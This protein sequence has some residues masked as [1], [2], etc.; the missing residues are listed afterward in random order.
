[1]H[2][3][4]CGTALPD[5]S[6]FCS[7]CGLDLFAT[8]PM[9]RLATGQASEADLAAEALSEEYDQFQEL[10]RGGMAL[11]YRARE[12][13]LERDVA[14]KVLPA[15]FTFDQEFVERFQREARTAARLEHPNI[16]PIYR[17]GRAGQ[18]IYFVMKYLRG[19][20]LSD[21]LK[22]HGRLRPAEIRR[23]LL[24]AG[25][26]LGY[27]AEHG[28]V[29]R[30]VKPD[31]IMLDEFGRT[32]LTDFGIAKAATRQRLTGT[33]LSIVTPRYMS[34]E[35]ARAQDTDF[36]SDIYSLGIVAFQCLTG[37]APFDGD[38]AFQ[39]GYKHVSEPL[40]RPRL[41][42]E[43]ERSLYGV[44]EKMVAKEPDSRFQSAAELEKALAGQEVAPSV[45]RMK[46]RMGPPV[47]LIPGDGPPTPPPQPA[48]LEPT[49]ASPVV[50]PLPPRAEARTVPRQD[51][52][53]RQ[54]ARRVANRSALMKQG[55]GSNF[56]IILILLLL[57]GGGGYWF[58]TRSRPEAG[59]ALGGPDSAAVAKAAAAESLRA[60]ADTGRSPSTIR[61]D[62]T[63][64]ATPATPAPPRDTARDTTPAV[65]AGSSDSGAIRIRNLPEGS[66]V[67]IDEQRA[68]NAITTLPAGTH[69]V[70]ISAPR[71]RFYA[72]TVSVHRN[73]TLLLAPVLTRLGQAAPVAPPAGSAT[74]PSTGDP[75]EPGPDW[76][77]T[78][79]FDVRPRPLSTPFVALPAGVQRVQR[80]A[81]FWIYVGLSGASEEVRL[82]RSSGNRAFD[83]A[84]RA[85]ATSLEWT[86]AQQHG[87]AV[88]AWTQMA[89]PPAR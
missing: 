35:Q 65:A 3:T 53:A 66:E 61:P 38:D 1:M 81:E 72:E 31:N 75:C 51:P 28:V 21:L 7:A 84:A 17:V 79:C 49:V 10:G 33:G 18:V 55:R 12:R 2:C 15:A 78:A 58:W 80:P 73:D 34:P 67:L 44:I 32:V 24:E 13:A 20:T 88:G 83:R 22:E 69:V 14:I 41:V 47:V 85:I 9:R 48:A 23:L 87:A 64:V 37:S 77:G 16:S 30:D 63:P 50:P 43:D 82:L 26:A 8:T 57:L 71:H 59:A 40:P 19:G 68:L 86:P 56:P 76:D 6:R 5:G 25:S 89:F 29:H 4:H 36:R 70:A 39:I 54:G 52:E 42:N 60:R 27:A 74:R 62:T 46:T 11:V 45:V